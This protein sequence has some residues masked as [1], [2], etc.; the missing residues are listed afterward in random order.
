[1]P[2][3][4]RILFFKQIAIFLTVIWTVITTI[5][6]FFQLHSEQKHIINH[7]ISNAK[8]IAQQT[9]YLIHW[10]FDQ[11][12][13]NLDKNSKLE[14]KTDFSLRDL[15]YKMS[16]ERGAKTVIESNYIQ[17]DFRNLDENII[18]TIKK[19]QESKKDQFSIYDLG[20]QTQLFYAKPLL[21]DG[22][23]SRCH[24]HDDKKAGDLIGNINLR[25]KIPTFYEFNQSS[26]MFLLFSYSITWMIGIVVIWWI[27]Y[28][29]RTFFDQRVKSYE[30]SIYSLVDMMEKRDS[31]TAGHS[32]RVAYYSSLLAA[33]LDCSKDDIDLIFQ[34]GMLHDI[35]KIEIPDALLLKPDI[36]TPEEYNLIKTHSKFGFELLCK[37]PFKNLSVIVLHHH[38]RYDGTGYPY[39]LSGAQI[40][41]LSQIISVA[42]AFDAMTTN[43]AYRKSFSI[44]EAI[45][46]IEEAS[47]TQF[48]PDIVKVARDVLEDIII[49]ENTTQMPKN[50][51]EEMKFSYYFKDQLTNCYNI[52]YLKFLFAHKNDYTKICTYHINCADFTGYNKK[53]GWKNG[54]ILLKHMATTFMDKFKEGI[55][56]RVFGDNFLII[57]LKEH[58]EMTPDILKYILCAERL[59]IRYNHIDLKEANIHTIEE[60]EDKL[61]NSDFKHFGTL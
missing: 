7:T 42:D 24:I 18:V 59:K 27:R 58:V 29:N 39:G 48:N 28:K 55:V 8:D 25:M 44:K 26:Y 60:L 5:F 15:I 61:L 34:A 49:P 14:L 36:L 16:E 50:I 41:L 20:E 43:R 12:A 51:M 2:T 52:N 32:K 40:P 46:K 4:N 10:A 22:S 37:E 11:K 19:M 31:Y 33:K 3:T 17:S 54:D 38:E 30:E 53:Y 47:G 56:V 13:K 9:E 1:M 57:H 6:F 23:C 45:E 35:G 21:D